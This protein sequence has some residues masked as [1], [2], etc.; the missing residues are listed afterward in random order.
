MKIILPENRWEDVHEYAAF[1]GARDAVLGKPLSPTLFN[2]NGKVARELRSC[3]ELGYLMEKESFQLYHECEFECKGRVAVYNE[4]TG[5]GS[6]AVDREG[7][8]IP[9]SY[10]VLEQDWIA[11][12]DEAVIKWVYSN[13]KIKITSVKTAS[14]LV[15]KTQKQNLKDA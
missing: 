7:L 10:H 6:V 15:W 11:E 9:F 8:N 5:W 3:Y 14:E 2:W 12:G 1:A 13:W 4:R